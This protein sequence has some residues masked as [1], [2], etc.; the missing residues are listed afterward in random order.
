MGKKKLSHSQKRVKDLL[1][2]LKRHSVTIMT[3]NVP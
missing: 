1:K 2:W 3:V